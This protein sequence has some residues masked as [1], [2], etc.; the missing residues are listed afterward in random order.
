MCGFT[1]DRDENAAWNVLQRGLDKVG[2]A[3]AESM[4]GETV[5]PTTTA[6]QPVAANHV[7]ETGS[8]TLKCEPQGER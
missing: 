1:A 5:V 2:T 4:P 7:A 3:S 8:P 6:F